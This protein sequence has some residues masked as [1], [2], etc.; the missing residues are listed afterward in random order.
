MPQSR[1]QIK[2]RLVKYAAE[3]WGYQPTDMDGFDPLVDLL[4]G[5]CAVEFERT[6]NQIASSQSRTLERLA[7]LLLP[8]SMVLPQPAHMVLRAPA[9]EPRYTLR[10]ED[11]FS[12]SKEVI[13]PAKPTEINEK[14]IYF[15]PTLPLPVF[16]GAIRYVGV[17]H[18]LLEQGNGLG[19]ERIATTRRGA[20][21][22]RQTLWLGVKL[23]PE[24]GDIPPL[25]LFFDWKNNP[26]KKK[27]FNLLAVTQVT[28][29]EHTVIT[30]S[31]YGESV[32]AHQRPDTLMHE[33]DSLPKIEARV[34]Q[35][36]QHHF[37][38]LHSPELSIRKNSTPY[39]T[40]FENHFEPEVLAGLSERLI[41]LRLSLSQLIPA[42]AVEGMICAINCFPACNRQ[43]I[44]NRRP[45]R[46]EDSL[47][48]VPLKT[49][50]Y[51]LAMHQ[52]RSGDGTPFQA[53]PFFNSHQMKPGTYAIRQNRVSKFDRRNA[54]EML[55]YVL[56]LMRDEAAAFSALGGTLGS[57]DILA[58]EQ[59]LNRIE[60]NLTRKAPDE[61]THHYLMLKPGKV[62]D[63][64]VSYWSTAGLLG[65]HIP[66]GS[67][68]ETRSVD[69]KSGAIVSITSSFGGTNKPSEQ[70][71]LYAFR[72]QLLSRDRL[73]T[74]EDIK[75]ACYAELGD[76]VARVEVK[77]GYQHHPAP[78]HGLMRVMEVV[79][80]PADEK[81]SDEAW[82]KISEE[83]RMNLDHRSSV[84]LPIRVRVA[85]LATTDYE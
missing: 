30:Q 38:T 46:L 70:E 17:G 41:W 37:L 56:E 78:T 2:R 21:F 28:V 27:Y 26:N 13:N 66:G 64:Y 83:L 47:N 72:S 67:V 73:V 9:V 65:N 81:L 36:Y 85:S 31:G 61:N 74:Q 54:R 80:T 18:Q 71:K 51:F 77:K 43:L 84:F 4:L 7:Q 62:K 69:V 15:S 34:N 60:E 68:G 25:R 5:A 12:F 1:T 29:G 53:V 6:A 42:E 82:A 76:T 20:E 39:P 32:V 23:N 79:L 59:H 57:R 16:D 10:A 75:A 48:I 14:P 63:V 33:W 50:D 45:Y 22:A 58:L 35:S 55:H 19:R 40:A 11:Q 3:L 49:D 44:D 24:L 52:M 8:E